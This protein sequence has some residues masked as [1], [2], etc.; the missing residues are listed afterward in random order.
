MQA[1]NIQSITNSV[2]NAYTKWLQVDTNMM[3]TE[4]TNVQENYS[5]EMEKISEM[6]DELLGMTDG[7][8]DPMMFTDASEY[9]GES[10]DAFLSR[11]L[12]TGDDIVELT[13]AMIDNFTEISLELPK[14]VS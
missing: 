13:H 4:L 9:F 1:Q 11:T 14:A 10:Q 7:V 8:I 12:L 2:S 6:T 3:M 5:E